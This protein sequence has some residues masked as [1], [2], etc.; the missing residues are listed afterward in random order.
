[1]TQTY[2][3]I[4]AELSPYS[5]KVRSYCRYKGLPHAWLLRSQSNELFEKHAKLPLIPLIVSPDGESKQDSTPIMEWLESRHP[6]PSIHP[7]DPV[8]RFVSFLLEEFGDEWGNKWMFHY[9]WARPA[10]QESAAARI[11]DAMMPVGD[12]SQKTAMQGAIV[13]R[14][15]DRV[16]FVGSSPATADQ[17]EDSYREVLGILDKHLAGRRFLFGNRPAFGDLGL[18]GQIYNAYTDP[19]AGEILRHGYA[20]VKDWLMRLLEPIPADARGEFETWSDLA[21]TLKPLVEGPVA[22]QFLPWTQANARALAA[23]DDEFSVALRG[24]E[25]RQKPLKYHARSYKALCE[26]YT[27]ADEDTRELMRNTG[28]DAFLAG[29]AP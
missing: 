7:S 19:T 12:E 21:P 3:L 9:R 25:W 4:G 14:M 20:Q 1:M 11:A 5:V 28:C 18:W 10:D 16:W 26:R 15:K 13:N 22:G 6:E 17:I 2:K 27:Q 8:L 24:R 29:V 23:G